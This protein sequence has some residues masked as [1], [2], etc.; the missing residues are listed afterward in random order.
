MQGRSHT[1]RPN[2]DV[3]T[4]FADEAHQVLQNTEGAAGLCPAVDGASEW[5]LRRIGRGV[6]REGSRILGRRRRH[7]ICACR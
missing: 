1:P 7:T 4:H 6:F 2:N 3:G 5:A